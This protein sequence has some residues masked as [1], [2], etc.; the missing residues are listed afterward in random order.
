VP[1]KKAILIKAL[2]WRTIDDYVAITKR[3][4]L[5]ASEDPVLN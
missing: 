1:V 2:N 5:W 3:L 4:A